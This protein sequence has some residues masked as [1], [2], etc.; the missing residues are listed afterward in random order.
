[1]IQGNRGH[2]VFYSKG[3]EIL[4]LESPFSSLT[5]P[6]GAVIPRISLNILKLGLKSPG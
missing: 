4:I 1:M 5:S 3:L 2:E 6:P